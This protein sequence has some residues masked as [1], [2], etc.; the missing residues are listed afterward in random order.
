MNFLD[1]SSVFSAFCLFRGAR[2]PKEYKY[3]RNF[4][5]KIWSRFVALDA[6]DA[7]VVEFPVFDNGEE[8]SESLKKKRFKLTAPRSLSEFIIIKNNDNVKVDQI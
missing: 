3:K 8:A 5:L 2:L 1:V 7:L 4:Y 6:L